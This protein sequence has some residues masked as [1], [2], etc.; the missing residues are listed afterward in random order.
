MIEG[1]AC[2]TGVISDIEMGPPDRSFPVASN[3]GRD[4]L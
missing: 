1:G 3:V 4:G 2:R